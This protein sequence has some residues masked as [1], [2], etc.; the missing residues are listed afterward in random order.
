MQ[1]C[2]NLIVLHNELANSGFDILENEPSK[3][4]YKGLTPSNDNSRI[5]SLQLRHLRDAQ[6][7]KWRAK[8]HLGRTTANSL[9]AQRSTRAA[10][11]SIH[12]YMDLNSS[13]TV[14]RVL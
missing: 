14:L 1:T 2:A 3:V 4:R 9:L 7:W 8:S 13:R 10:D 5:P 11:V 6:A 12:A